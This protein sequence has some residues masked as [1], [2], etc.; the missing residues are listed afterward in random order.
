MKA[1]PLDPDIVFRSH[2][3]PVSVGAEG[4]IRQTVASTM[5]V[6]RERLRADAPD[7]YVV[8]AESQTAGRGREGAWQCPEGAGLL[9]SVILRIGL[10]ASAQRLIVLTGAVA[11]AE[12]LQALGVPA[13]I[14]WPNDVVVASVGT[15]GLNVRKL[16]GLLVERVVGSGGTASYILG[17]GLNINQRAAD[18]P[19]DARI[20]PTSMRLEVGRTVDRNAVCRAVLGEL[21]RWYRRLA[22]GQHERILARWRRLSCLLGRRVCALVDGESINGRVLGIRSTGELIFRD[23]SG[24]Q[25]LLSHEKTRLLV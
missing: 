11:A 1:V 24:A 3:A 5:D 10:P 13:L 14:K 22:L 15:D 25:R 6:A 23:G 8:L 17:I 7:G 4:E 12:A 2:G 21:N 20:R 19:T 16:G 9:M 18:L